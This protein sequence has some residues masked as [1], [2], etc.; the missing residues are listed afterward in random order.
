MP[1]PK[2][3]KNKQNK[4]IQYPGLK[5]PR[6]R[7]RKNVLNIVKENNETAFTQNENTLVLSEHDLPEI[8][9]NSVREFLESYKLNTF[10]GFDDWDRFS[11]NI[12]YNY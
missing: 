7:P 10:D 8:E 12:D 5:R 9:D 2:G 6:G 3:S 11:I 4:V 1:R